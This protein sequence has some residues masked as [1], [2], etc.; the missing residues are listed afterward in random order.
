[1][2]TTVIATTAASSPAA[3]STTVIATTAA[4]SKNFL[5]VLGITNFISLTMLR[6]VSKSVISFIGIVFNLDLVYITFRTRSLHGTCN[7]LIALNALF[8]AFFEFSHITELIIASAKLNPVPLSHCFWLQLFPLFGANCT[9][10]FILFIGIDR[11]ISIAFPTWHSRIK[12]R[13]YLTTIIGLCFLYSL[14]M[15]FITFLVVFQRY[16][17]LGLG[18]QVSDLYRDEAKSLIERNNIILNL[19][20]LGC[21]IGVWILIKRA[22]GD[23]SA[24]L[25][26]SL[27]AIMLSVFGGWFLF[28]IATMIIDQFDLVGPTRWYILFCAG[29]LQSMS[30]ASHA[31][32]LYAFSV[33]YRSAF[34]H[35]FSQIKA[36]MFCRKSET[37]TAV[38]FL[39]NSKSLQ[40]SHS[41]E[42]HS[43]RHHHDKF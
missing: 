19:T 8:T 38:L 21:Y 35:Q 13:Y 20:T 28:S 31:P 14:T 41:L 6:V 34:R 37:N 24:R 7:L 2:S 3:M 43:T 17:E 29:L 5:V 42:Q 10:I 23:V 25:F 22:K 4:S 12:I 16:P 9:I 33:P 36:V 30:D 11:L 1:M 15:A 18:C 32:I 40:R 27:T 39:G 26:K